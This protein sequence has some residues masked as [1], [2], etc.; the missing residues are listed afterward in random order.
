MLH[1][2]KLLLVSLGSSALVNAAITKSGS[3]VNVDGIFYYVLATSVSKLGLSSDQLKAAAAPEEDLIP[4]TVMRGDF[5][6]FDA[7]TFQTNVN[8]FVSGDDVFGTGFLQGM[9]FSIGRRSR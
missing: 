1:I 5:A 9:T 6:T 4:L 2:F 7:G 3:T 8:T